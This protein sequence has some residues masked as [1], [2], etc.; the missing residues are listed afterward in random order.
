MVYVIGHEL[1]VEG[2]GVFGLTWLRIAAAQPGM[3][4]SVLTNGFL[5]FDGTVGEGVVP[6]SSEQAAAE[7]AQQL[8]SLSRSQCP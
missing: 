3:A 6:F 8:Q 2:R 7:A 1:T 4:K 5:V